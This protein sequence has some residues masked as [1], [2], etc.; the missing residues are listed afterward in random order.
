MTPPASTA[1]D[2]SGNGRTG[3]YNASGAATYF[4]RLT[5]GALVSDTPDRAVTLTNVALSSGSL[6]INNTGITMQPTLVQP[7]DD[8]TVFHHIIAVGN[9]SGEAE[10]LFDQ[11]DGE[12]LLLQRPNGI[13]DLLNDNRRKSFGRLI[14]Q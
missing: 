8:A 3:T 7:V 14:E 1:A 5:D 13:A 4:T 11:K 6:V 2:T 10:V 9:G 12:T